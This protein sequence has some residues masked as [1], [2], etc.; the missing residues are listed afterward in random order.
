MAA[1]KEGS[2]EALVKFDERYPD[3]GLDERREQAVNK[4]YASLQQATQSRLRE[5]ESVKR[6]V[7]ALFAYADQLQL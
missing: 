1:E 5:E 7:A 6:A 2:L 3:L 4:Q